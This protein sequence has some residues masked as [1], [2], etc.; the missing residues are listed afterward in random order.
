MSHELLTVSL[1]P[2]VNDKR[3]LTVIMRGCDIWELKNAEGFSLLESRDSATSL[4]YS[5]YSNLGNRLSV[6]VSYI[7][8]PPRSDGF[9]LGTDVCRRVVHPDYQGGRRSACSDRARLRLIR[10]GR[11]GAPSSRLPPG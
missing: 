7:D 5:T 8:G 4:L 6:Y 1:T 2:G 3:L 10:V 9:N 11:L